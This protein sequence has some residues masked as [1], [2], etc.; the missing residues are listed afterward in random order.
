MP[1]SRQNWP[2]L[3]AP[4]R[5]RDASTPVRSSTSAGGASRKKRT[6]TKTSSD[7]A[8][9]AKQRDADREPRGD[10]HR[11]ARRATPSGHGHGDQHQDDQQVEERSA[12]PAPAAGR[13]VA[14]QACADAGAPAEHRLGHHVHE[15]AV[16]HHGGR[17]PRRRRR[18]TSPAWRAPCRAGSPVRRVRRCRANRST[19]VAGGG[20]HQGEQRPGRARKRVVTSR[21]QPDH[22]LRVAPDR[23]ERAVEEVAERRAG[24]GR[25][26]R[27]CAPAARAL[28]VVR[29]RPV[30]RA[31]GPGGRAGTGGGA[32]GTQ[33]GG[34][35]SDTV[36]PRAVDVRR[37]RTRR[38]AVP[39]GRSGPDLITVARSLTR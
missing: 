1:R 3:S 32:G 24:A 21:R 27:A 20:Q 9:A 11:D 6:C 2:R 26:R 4:A 39:G 33:P 13:V 28:A 35:G 19:R 10:A 18:G 5:R 37:R 7:H 36:V 12:R 23:L 8:P 34:G 38:R 15:H 16:E 31:R 25:R 30:R 17:T 14:L 29:A 22:R